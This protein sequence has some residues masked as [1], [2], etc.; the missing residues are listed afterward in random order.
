ML[1]A[2]IK[3]TIGDLT[4]ALFLFSYSTDIGTK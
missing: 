1:A 3:E 2:L 4:A